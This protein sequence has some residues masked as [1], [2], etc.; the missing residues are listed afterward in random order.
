MEIRYCKEPGNEY[1]AKCLEQMK[2]IPIKTSIFGKKEKIQIKSKGTVLICNTEVA[3]LKW[4]AKEIEQLYE[5][6]GK[7]L[8][9]VTIVV[10]DHF[11]D[12]KIRIKYIKDIALKGLNVT[13]P[14]V[15][16]PV[17]FKERDMV[18]R[19]ENNYD[20][21]IDTKYM[22]KS[23]KKALRAVLSLYQEKAD[24]KKNHVRRGEEYADRSLV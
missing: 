5:W 17:E 14:P 2:D 7:D 20:H 10:T 15:L 22:S 3:S 11:P 4:L 16:L 23:Y 19:I 12:S 6:Q 1:F 21:K 8:S 24:K 18:Y 9:L 13:H